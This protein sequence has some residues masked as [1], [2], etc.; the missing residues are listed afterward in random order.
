MGRPGVA[1]IISVIAL[2]LRFPYR[3]G[4]IRRRGAPLFGGI[5][6]SF[7]SHAAALAREA[8]LETPC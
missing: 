1:K 6:A 7:I 4:T 3:N 8:E 5:G 2:M